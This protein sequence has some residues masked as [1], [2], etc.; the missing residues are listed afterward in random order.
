[1]KNHKQILFLVILLFS[2]TL[3]LPAC[4][5]P[6][7]NKTQKKQNV[8]IKRI[9]PLDQ[10][11]KKE[12]TEQPKPE[13]TQEQAK[14]TDPVN[15]QKQDAIKTV[16]KTKE[17]QKVDQASKPKIDQAKDQINQEQTVVT[18]T[19][20]ENLP[21][22]KNLRSEMEKDK[23]KDKHYISEGKIDPFMSPITKRNATE[24]KKILNRKLS[25]LEKLDL[26]QL[27]LVAIILMQSGKKNVAMVQESSGKGYMV[28]V[29]TYI[30]T[31]NGRI[32]EIKN[33]EIIIKE[34]VKN[35]KGVFEDRLKPMKLQKKDNG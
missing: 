30:G 25:P 4:D 13:P 15:N 7:Q 21:V 12:K 33:D 3:L 34:R 23:E 18:K 22:S 16:D 5:T 20:P 2:F 24:E 14:K 35:F 17:Q 10:S 1:M 19:D 27:K 8:V 29:G 28:K 9:I 26:S 31:N 6:P 11:D 32:I